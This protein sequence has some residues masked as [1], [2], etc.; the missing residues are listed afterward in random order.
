M[1]L[2]IPGPVVTR[3]EVKAA[4]AQDYAPW[5]PDFRA[6][7]AAVRAR[8]L[9][10]AGADPAT[11][12]VLALQGC[13]HFAVEA[14]IRTFVSPQRRMLV[15]MTGDYADH[16]VRLAREAGRDVVT[17]PVGET[18]R[19]DPRAVAAALERDPTIS[20]VGLVYS[21]TGSGIC[22]DVIATGRLVAA[23]GRR[24]LIDAVSA[25]GALPLDV[26]AM[27]ETDAVVFT[28]N[29]CLEGMPGLGFI[30]VP[31]ERVLASAG[32]AGSWSFDLA[33]VYKHGLSKPPGTWRFTP[34]VQAVA[35][36]LTALDL[37]DAEGGQP[38]RLAR[39]TA[40]ML[41]LREGVEALGLS[42]YLPAALQGPIVVNVHAPE[43][44]S[45][46]L[47]AFVRALKR[48]GILISNFYN[49]SRPTFRVGCIGAVT[50][51]DM[52][53]AVAMIAASIED[54]CERR[55]QRGALETPGETSG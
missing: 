10:L 39:Y 37:Y 46:D 32:N 51:Q 17:L 3:P 19:M 25:F 8:L 15:P 40:N 6:L 33:D 44:C 55:S 14:A 13:G 24:T 20:H 29:K 50:P 16:M 12:T 35:A 2:L 1:L 9:R 38:A 5:D 49:T 45:W 11:H 43:R 31:I 28:S 53:H 42:P 48:R 41:C 54:L 27:P 7:H 30:V 21:E 36:L 52:R 26:S 18:E 23:L 47:Q 22:H 4:F 34:A